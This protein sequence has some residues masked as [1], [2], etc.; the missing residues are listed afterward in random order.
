MLWN[1][2]KSE[3]SSKKVAWV[4]KKVVPCADPAVE[5]VQARFCRDVQPEA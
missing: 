5:P 1:T 2:W 4:A 3:P